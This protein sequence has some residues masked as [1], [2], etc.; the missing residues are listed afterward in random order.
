[1]RESHRHPFVILNN[2]RVDYIAALNVDAIMQRVVQVEI[3]QV[4]L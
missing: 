2:V 4:R 3:Q 1:M